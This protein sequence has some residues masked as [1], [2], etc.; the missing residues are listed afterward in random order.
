MALRII[1]CLE[2]YCTAQHAAALV[3]AAIPKFEAAGGLISKVDKS[4]GAVELDDANRQWDYSYGWAP[5]RML[6]WT[7]LQRYETLSGLPTGGYL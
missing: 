1:P 4:R 5:Q 2:D 3:A 7:G 6:A